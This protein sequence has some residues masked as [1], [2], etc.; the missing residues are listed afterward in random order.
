MP[1]RPRTSNR[2]AWFVLLSCL[3]LALAGAVALASW[4]QEPD[5]VTNSTVDLL[6][7]RRKLGLAERSTFIPRPVLSTHELNAWL[8]AY[9][10]S[11]K[12][13]PMGYGLLRYARL[14]TLSADIT[15]S[16]ITLSLTGVWGAVLVGNFRLGP[17]PFSLSIDGI[18][19]RR[20][21]GFGFA[22]KGGNIG[23]LPLPGP[24]AALPA[25]IFSDL[26]RPANKEHA[27]LDKITEFYLERHQVTLTLESHE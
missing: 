24:T 1:P 25:M 27:V 9:Q 23:H 21:T 13:K 26:L 7:A 2:H 5:P 4:P 11:R 8:A 6:Q 12:D 18:P 3:A 20:Q 17:W 22:I 14:K 10:E 16:V 19:Q 15:P